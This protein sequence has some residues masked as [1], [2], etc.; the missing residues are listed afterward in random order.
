MLVAHPAAASGLA[1]VI[2]SG[3]ASISLV[4]MSTQKE[5]RRIPVLREPHHLALSPDGT[6]PAGRRH[7]RQRDA[8]PRSG[9]RGGAEAH[10]GGRSVSA[11]LQPERQVPGGERPR[12]QPGRRLRRRQHAVAEALP[13]RVDAEPSGLRAGFLA[14]VRQPAGH[15]QPGG[16]RSEQAGDPVD[17]EDRQDAGRRAVARRQACWSPTWAPITSRW[18]IRRTGT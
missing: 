9:D 4:D 14:R 18:S 1:F 13:D 17:R 7:R 3:G 16:D 15:R 11:R 12:A 6:K 10:A 2:N 5:L 8:V